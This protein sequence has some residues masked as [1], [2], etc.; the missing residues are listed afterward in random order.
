MVHHS[1]VV[2]IKPHVDKIAK[3]LGLTNKQAK[4]TKERCTYILDVSIVNQLN[5]KHHVKEDL[6]LR[7]LGD[8]FSTEESA[9]KFLL[10]IG[11]SFV[12][13]SGLAWQRET[14]EQIRQIV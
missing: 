4:L 13:F 5:L 2:I 8:F 11:L 10:S 9:M 3:V 12:E 6:T 7:S 1:T 14:F